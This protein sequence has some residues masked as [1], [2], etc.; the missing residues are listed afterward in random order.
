MHVVVEAWSLFG[1][2]APRFAAWDEGEDFV[3]GL[4][5]FADGVGAGVGSKGFADG[6]AGVAGEDDTGEGFFSDGDVGVAFVI[7]HADVVGGPVFFDEVAFEHE[8]F[9]F[10][11]DDNGFDIADFADESF[12]S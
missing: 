1:L 5:S 6:F 2:S 10:A 7:A 9:E 12:Y 3:E 11:I 4:E 8:G